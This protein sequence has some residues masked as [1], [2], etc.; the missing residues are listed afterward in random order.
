MS[1]IFGQLLM[2]TCSSI[3]TLLIFGMT[4]VIRRLPAIFAVFMNIMREF[5]R[6]SYHLYKFILSPLAVIIEDWVGINILNNHWRV[7]FTTLLS[8]GLGYGLFQLGGFSITKLTLVFF[9]A[10]GL[11]IGFSWDALGNPDGLHLGVDLK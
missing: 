6:T 9:Y 11:I 10:H 4:G 7:P 1:A 8:L 5:C 3:T 2:V